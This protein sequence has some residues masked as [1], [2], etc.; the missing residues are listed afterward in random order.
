[1][2]KLISLLLFVATLFTFVSCGDDDEE[3]K[4]AP[5]ES[6]AEESE[7]VYTLT[8]GE[9]TY[10]VPYELYRAFF[11]NHKSEVDKGNGAVWSGADK[12]K[13][14]N[15]IDALVL[16]DITDIYSVFALCE[17]VGIDIYSETVEGSIEQYIIASVEGGTVGGMVFQGY[18]GDYNAYLA[19]LKALNMNYSVQALLFRYA[20]CSEMI[21]AYF[22]SSSNGGTLAVQKDTVRSFYYNECVRVIKP[23]FPTV[24]DLDKEINSA[25][26]MNTIKE[27]MVARASDED[28]VCT[29][30]ITM[31]TEGENIRNGYFIGR[32]SL[33]QSYYGELTSVAFSLGMHEVSDP[34]QIFS[35]GNSGYHILY[36]AEQSDANFEACYSSI[37][38]AYVDNYIGKL[39]FNTKSTL[40]ASAVATSALNNR[41]RASIS[42]G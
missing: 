22:A 35:G 39:L 31:S 19:N 7:A 25:K 11:L 15:E 6:T 18:G 10:N 36:R 33:D 16:S 24:T 34:I 12:Q 41:D 23:F 8:Y 2:K 14:I 5:V 37:E 40:T 29:Y 27:G 13:Y 26:R 38:K 28:A 30:I 42:M 17:S 3:K 20:V 32:Y 9:K 4:Y 21:D 1:M